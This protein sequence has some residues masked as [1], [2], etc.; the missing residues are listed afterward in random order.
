[1][2]FLDDYGAAFRAPLA[3]RTANSNEIQIKTMQRMYRLHQRAMASRGVLVDPVQ[4]GNRRWR[5]WLALRRHPIAP[6]LDPRKHPGITPGN[7][8]SLHAQIDSTIEVGTIAL[9]II[10]TPSVLGMV[11]TG[12]LWWS[13]AEA[14]ER[15]V[16]YWNADFED[17]SGTVAYQGGIYVAPEYR[18]QG[19]GW[20]LLRM[21]RWLG[22]LYFDAVHSIGAFLPEISQGMDPYG[23]DGYAH[24]SEVAT[25]LDL[26]HGPQT[27]MLAAVSKPAALAAVEHETAEIFR[28]LQSPQRLRS[29]AAGGTD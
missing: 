5:K 6:A 26:G 10:T 1:M 25:D 17:L 8:I 21:V 19:V 3:L 16:R 22:F 2:K 28:R 11:Q 27:V 4:D 14:V 9:R 20:H 18:G 24:L 13:V 29:P 23:Y 15:E 7:A 12:A